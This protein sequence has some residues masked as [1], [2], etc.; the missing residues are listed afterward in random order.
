MPSR[1]V[2]A[3]AADIKK[4]S[5]KKLQKFLKVI[6]KSGLL[7]TKE[8]RGE[9]MIMSI[10][11]SHPTLQQV[12]KYKTIEQQPSVAIAPATA[13]S[14]EEKK[15]AEIQE[16]FK[17]MGSFILR[18]FDEAQQDKDALYTFVELRTILNDYVKEHELVNPKNQK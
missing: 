1:P 10:Q 12:T 17:P 7:K 5:W 6:E 8:Q 13:V 9:T 15:P 11:W 4:S 3:E 18:F 2:G 16:F 14:H